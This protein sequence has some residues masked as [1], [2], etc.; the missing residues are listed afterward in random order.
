LAPRRRHPEIEWRVAR[1]S[2]AP[3]P[4][5]ATRPR[6]P[7]T[8][9]TAE[10]SCRYLLQP[11]RRPDQFDQPLDQLHAFSL[12]YP[13]EDGIRL[14][15]QFLRLNEALELRLML[16]DGVVEARGVEVL[17]GVVLHLLGIRLVLVAP[18]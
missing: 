17:G 13:P 12:F 7:C 5:R 16:V 18:I 8:P 1:F 15:R 14:E 2:S 9:D 10:S 4:P 11:V 6:C 3:G